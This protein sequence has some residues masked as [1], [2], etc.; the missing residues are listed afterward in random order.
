[1]RVLKGDELLFL[2]LWCSGYIGAKLG[3][4]VAGPFTLLLYRFLVMMLVVAVMTA[5][6]WHGLLAALCL[7]PLAWWFEGFAAAWGGQLVFAIIWL[8]I[9]VSIGAYGLMFYLIRTRDATRISALQYFVPPVTMM[10]AWAVF[11]EALAGLGFLGL[12]ITSVGFYLMS[13]SQRRANQ[14]QSVCQ[15]DS[16]SPEKC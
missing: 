5:L 2:L 15:A 6:F 1:M 7:A 11:G 14:R 12:F 16:A 13:L 8:A 9:P 10:I 3:V 4:P